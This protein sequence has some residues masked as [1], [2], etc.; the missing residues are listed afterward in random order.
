MKEP[1]EVEDMVKLLMGKDSNY[2]VTDNH[3]AEKKPVSGKKCP[4][5][6][7]KIYKKC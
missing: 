5:G 6:S 2:I 3:R 7:K 4:C 1:M